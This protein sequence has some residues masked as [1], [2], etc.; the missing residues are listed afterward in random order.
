MKVAGQRC[1]FSSSPVKF[2]L[3][4][5]HFYAPARLSAR[6]AAAQ[7]SEHQ[8]DLLSEEWLLKKVLASY[9]RCCSCCFFFSDC[10][11]ACFIVPD[12]RPQ[13][14]LSLFSLVLLVFAVRMTTTNPHFNLLSSFHASLVHTNDFK[15]S[16]A[17]TGLFHFCHFL[18]LSEPV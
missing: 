17:S 11:H 16:R 14:L 3:F 18:D 6:A 10:E 13:H 4:L 5:D 7:I 8:S 1:I 2:L 12:K 15:G 9:I